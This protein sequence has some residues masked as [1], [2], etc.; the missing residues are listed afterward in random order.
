MSSEGCQQKG[1]E[2]E[3]G[4][5]FIRIIPN[6]KRLSIGWLL[7]GLNNWDENN[8][9]RAKNNEVGFVLVRA[10]NRKMVTKNVG[11]KDSV[12]KKT[13]IQNCPFTLLACKHNSRYTF[14]STR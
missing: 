7:P 14:L 9:A 11:Q 6:P 5:A 2:R 10:Y 12:K 3:W 4:D 8:Q 1:K 13:G